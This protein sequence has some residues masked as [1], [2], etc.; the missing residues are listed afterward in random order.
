MVGMHMVL[1]ICI[2]YISIIRIMYIIVHFRCS[3][4]E[5]CYLLR[6]ND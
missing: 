5:L 3:G 6:Q 4:Y 1:I 2:V